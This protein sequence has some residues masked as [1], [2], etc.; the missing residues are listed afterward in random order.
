V[1]ELCP[2]PIYLRKQD[3]QDLVALRSYDQGMADG[4]KCIVCNSIWTGVTRCH[5]SGC[6]KTFSS[7]STFDRHQRW[8]EHRLTCLD[9][10][11]LDLVWVDGVWR[12]APMTEEEKVKAFG[13][14][15]GG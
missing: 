3:D 11:D 8:S 4:F 9:P 5:C 2:P 7:P 15:Y 14:S 10:E 6:H 12:T 13:G 1:G